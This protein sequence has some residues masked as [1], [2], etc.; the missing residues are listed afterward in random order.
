MPESATVLDSSSD[1]WEKDVLRSELPVIAF[2]WTPW[3]QWSR[4]LDPIYD[5]LA[6]QYHGRIRTLKINADDNPDIAKRYGVESTPTIKFFFFGRNIG[7][8]VGYLPREQLIHEFEHIL[9]RDKE[10]IQT[11]NP[12]TTT[13]LCPY[14]GETAGCNC[15]IGYGAASGGG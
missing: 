14:C 12:I 3:C 10:V 9:H 7:E 15:C 11:T 6:S 2:F 1:T 5:E 8:I 13:H 4:L